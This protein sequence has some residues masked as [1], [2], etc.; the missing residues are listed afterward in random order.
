M[1]EIPTYCYLLI[2]LKKHPSHVEN[3]EGYLLTAR[4]M[5]WFVD[6]YVGGTG[7]D[8]ADPT[9]SPAGAS[10]RRLSHTARAAIITAGYDPLRDEGWAYAEA[11]RAAGVTVDH[12]EWE[13]QI[14][15]FFGLREAIPEAGEA[16]EWLADRARE[17]FA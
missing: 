12:R 7:I 11:L 2:C 17:A 4:M 3:G 1:L 15:A 5:T 14:H 16:I 9:V 13:G 10:S 6:L 8:P